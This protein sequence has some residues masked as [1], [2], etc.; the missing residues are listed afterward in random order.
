MTKNRAAQ[1]RLARVSY[2]MYLDCGR[3]YTEAARQLGCTPT[4][5]RNRVRYHLNGGTPRSAAQ[6]T[7]LSASTLALLRDLGLEN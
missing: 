5:V 3:N 6:Q 1:A 4:T 2:D 7:T